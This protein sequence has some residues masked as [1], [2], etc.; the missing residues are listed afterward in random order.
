MKLAAEVVTQSFHDCWVR[1]YDG[2]QRDCSH[3]QC[4]AD[5]RVLSSVVSSRRCPSNHR[6]HSKLVLRKK[7]SPNG[8]RD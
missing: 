4:H 1:S 5:V 8:N 2:I 3:N 7:T 6:I